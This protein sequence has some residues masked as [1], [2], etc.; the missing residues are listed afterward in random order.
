MLRGKTLAATLT[1]DTTTTESSQ[2]QLSQAKDAWRTTGN[3]IWNKIG[4]TVEKAKTNIG[5][6]EVSIYSP[7]LADP[8]YKECFLRTSTVTQLRMVK[9]WQLCMGVDFSSL[10]EQLKSGI[11]DIIQQKIAKNIITRPIQI[12][13]QFA[14]CGTLSALGFTTAADIAIKRGILP[15]LIS[16]GPVGWV[17]AV[18]T[19]FIPT[20]AFIKQLFE[21]KIVGE[22]KIPFPEETLKVLPYLTSQNAEA[23]F[24]LPDFDDKQKGLYVLRRL[25][26]MQS[27]TETLATPFSPNKF[28]ECARQLELQSL[29]DPLYNVNYTIE[30]FIKKFYPIAVPF[31]IT[32]DENPIYLTDSQPNSIIIVGSAEYIRRWEALTGHSILDPVTI[33]PAAL[34]QAIAISGLPSYTDLLFQQAWKPPMAFPDEPYRQMVLCPMCRG[35]GYIASESSLVLGIHPKLT[36]STCPKCNGYGFVYI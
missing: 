7:I 23:L 1:G 2:D 24:I 16:L 30:T 36:L 33:S 11:D 27:Y 4:T 14:L 18:G 26:E 17:L 20:P 15:A 29:Y 8:F 6:A 10:V 12:A 9:F 3:T 22:V 35:R 5:G 28:M 13:E 32:F 19:L 31:D 25:V 34:N 21:L